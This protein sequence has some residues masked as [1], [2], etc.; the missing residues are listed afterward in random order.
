MFNKI[1]EAVMVA[2]KMYYKAL[3]VC[4]DGEYNVSSVKSVGIPCYLV[5]LCL[6][7][8]PVAESWR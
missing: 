8:E 6:L 7:K 4:S 1:F 5:N 3:K 2:V